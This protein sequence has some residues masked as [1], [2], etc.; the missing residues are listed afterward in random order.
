M[1]NY[2]GTP[3]L[4][5]DSN[6]Q[7]TSEFFAI[8]GTVLFWLIFSIFS[9]VIKPQPDKPK[10]K[11]VQI[12]LSSTPVVQK[13]EEAPAPAEAASA[14]AASSE[15][16]VEQVVE[17][18]VVEV[19]A[20]KVET[21]P[22]VKETP[23]SPKAV[24]KKVETPKPKAP[25]K[26][27]PKKEAPKTQTPKKEETPVTYAKSVDEL[28]AEQFNSKPSSKPKENFEEMFKDDEVPAETTP[29]TPKLV[30]TQNTIDGSAGVSSKENIETIK[31]SSG[32]K[33]YTNE[34]ITHGKDYDKIRNAEGTDL[35]DNQNNSGKSQVPST[36]KDKES[37]IWSNDSG[38]RK[39]YNLDTELSA[40]ARNSM[41][42]SKTIPFKISFS[43]DTN[44]NVI[45]STITITNE[46]MLT[47]IINKEMR[48]KISSWKFSSGDEI[49]KAVFIWNLAPS[50]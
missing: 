41:L 36:G 23:P 5:E 11:E 38:A 27:V 20:P 29:S 8:A 37:V 22:V 18:P 21:P 35:G 16:I 34:D 32:Q 28:M 44:G 43:V 33:K 17:A 49:S 9:F 6:P 50:N 14:S 15:S 25:S 42:I 30:T 4:G 48:Q 31:S 24:E 2:K 10:Y 12:V 39:Q 13:T 46:F 1:I 3:L 7:H 47:D 26:P 19:P 45:A 40:A